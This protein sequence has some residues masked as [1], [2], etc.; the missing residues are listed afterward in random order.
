M[1]NPPLEEA[2]IVPKGEMEEDDLEDCQ[3]GQGEEEE[4]ARIVPKRKV[5]KEGEKIKN[6]SG[7]YK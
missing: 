7:N 3:W 1:S 4:E 5:E 2:R 6:L